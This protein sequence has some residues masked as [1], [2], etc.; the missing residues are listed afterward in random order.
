MR[1]THIIVAALIVAA[2][3]GCS[4]KEAG[5]SAES[6]QSTGFRGEFAQSN[7]KAESVSKTNKVVAKEQLLTDIIIAAQGAQDYFGGNYYLTWTA[8]D[9]PKYKAAIDFND[10]LTSAKSA[11]ENGPG[12]HFGPGGKPFDGAIL[13]DKKGVMEFAKAMT[14]PKQYEDWSKPLDDTVSK[15]LSGDAQAGE[16][17]LLRR[18]AIDTFLQAVSPS[19]GWPT[20]NDIHDDPNAEVNQSMRIYM[21]RKM[22]ELNFANLF[23]AEI[24]RIMPQN[25]KNPADLRHDFI[26]AVVKIPNSAYYAMFKQASDTA[27]KATHIVVGMGDPSW[28]SDVYEYDGPP[29]GWTYRVGG[30]VVF[31]Q[32]YI[33]SQLYEVEV[34]SALEVSA[35]KERTDRQA[36]SFGT[37]QADKATVGVK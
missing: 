17:F 30:Q 6:S 3:A 13:R 31:G 4:H 19:R 22:R 29:T 8:K 20:Y 26:E 36:E 15:Y 25:F 14:L 34:A 18:L 37:D 33:N 10:A 21:N 24:A 35:K 28:T 1:T 27:A 9:A 7:T 2:L 23:A 12:L 32:G 5:V 11:W 16:D